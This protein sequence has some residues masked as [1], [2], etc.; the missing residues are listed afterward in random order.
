MENN[1]KKDDMKQEGTKQES[2]KHDEST[3]KKLGDKIEHAGQKMGGGLG[4]K[5]EKLG[6]KIEHS[7][8]DKSKRSA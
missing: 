5:V 1:V 6:D 2:S 4:E 3:T 7:R 8:D